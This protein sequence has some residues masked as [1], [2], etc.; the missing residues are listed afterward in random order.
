M[1]IPESVVLDLLRETDLLQFKEEIIQKLQITKIEHFEH[2]KESDLKVITIKYYFKSEKFN[3][4][5]KLKRYSLIGY[6]LVSACNQK[7][8]KNGKRKKKSNT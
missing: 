8:F 2:V 7:T 4:F 3:S 1:S 6:R 5:W